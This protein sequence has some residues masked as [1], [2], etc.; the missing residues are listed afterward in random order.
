MAVVL[1]ILSTI[2]IGTGEFVAGGVT[3]RTRANEVSATMFASGTI[4]TAIIAILWRGDPTMS[5]MMFGALAGVTNGVGI[6]LL[7]L[8]YSRGSLRS[9]APTAAVVMSSVPILWDVLV[10]RTAPSLLTWGGITLGVV[11]IALSSYQQSD[12]QKDENATG[13]AITAGIVFGVLFIL[14]GEIAREAGGAPL[15]AQRGVGFIVAVIV[16]RSTGKHIFPTERAVLAMSLVVGLFATSAM[17]LM[18]LALQAGGSLSVVSVIGSQYAAVAVI[19]GLVFRGQRL[20]WW[21]AVG[22]TTASL[23]VAL[24]SLG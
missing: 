6:L 19:L 11:A 21:Q 2:C 8:A 12:N 5:D 10:K 1:A 23:A 18:V 13:L 15:L 7:Y 14:L 22:L 24:I 9:A 3:K 20:T 4:M 17:V 16:S